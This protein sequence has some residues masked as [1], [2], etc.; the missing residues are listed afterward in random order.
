M[1]PSDLW[2]VF[3]CALLLL[4]IG[5]AFGAWIGQSIERARSRSTRERADWLEKRLARVE[6]AEE[7]VQR[8]RLELA[9]E[10]ARRD[11]DHERLAWIHTAEEQLGQSFQS[12]ASKLLGDG[13]ETLA[14]RGREELRGIVEPL[15]RVL[16][17]LDSHVRALEKERQ[18]AYA[19]LQREL[20]QLRDAHRELHGTARDLERALR[21]SGGRGRWGEVQLRRII[22]LAGLMEHVDFDEQPTLDSGQRPDLVVRLPGGGSVPVDAKTPMDAYFRAVS[23]DDPERRD[24][25]FGAHLAALDRR[26]AELGAKEYWRRLEG[27]PDFVV[28][29]LPVE[30]CL[31]AA[32]ER[33]PALL[34]RCLERRVLPATPITLLALLKTVAWGWRRQ[35]ADESA[36]RIVAAGRELH[37]RLER[38]L[39]HLGRAG[40]GLGSAVEAYNLAVG[41]LERR[42]LPSVRRLENLVAADDPLD[43][44]EPITQSPRLGGPETTGED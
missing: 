32:F 39:S 44:P 17:G 21:S 37:G 25:L 12:L 28:I 31:S 13:V 22:E 1:A 30:G 18:G 36:A 24:Q 5:A 8:L 33:D 2:V 29:F 11:A 4:A 40:H 10:R 16:S 7:E 42:V 26:S 3:L 43:S 23:E 27:S 35:N 14:G 41:S 19:G 34:D 20:G 38:F 9:E 6:P 15:E